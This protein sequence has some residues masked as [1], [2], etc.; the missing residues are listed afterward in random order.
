M[1]DNSFNTDFCLF[2]VRFE[3]KRGGDSPVQERASKEEALAPAPPVGGERNKLESINRTGNKRN[4][5]T[6]YIPEKA[7]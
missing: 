5:E 2:F 6:F 4:G 1:F 7:F 3:N